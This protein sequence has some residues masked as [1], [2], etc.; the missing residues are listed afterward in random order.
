MDITYTTANAAG[1][2]KKGTLLDVSGIGAGLVLDEP[3][4][5]NQTLRLEGYGEWD[6]PRDAKVR[7]VR[8]ANEHYRIGVEF[9][10]PKP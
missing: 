9:L 2:G 3:M 10:S 1:G 6:E 4:S 5:L 7:W 8:K